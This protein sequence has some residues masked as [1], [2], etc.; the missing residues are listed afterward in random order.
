MHAELASTVAARKEAGEQL[1][2]REAG[3][4]R[5]RP[6]A[7][8]RRQLDSERWRTIGRGQRLEIIPGSLLSTGTLI[9][10][11]SVTEW[12]SGRHDGDLQ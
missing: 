4:A 2:E 7:D 11:A 6:D 1:A 9:A 10:R 3:G 8:C 5:R 12:R